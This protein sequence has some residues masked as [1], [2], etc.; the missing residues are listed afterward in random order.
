MALL[1]SNLRVEKPRHREVRSCPQ[2]H[3]TKQQHLVLNLSFLAPELTLNPVLLLPLKW[4]HRDIPLGFQDCWPFKFQIA[5]FL[6]FLLQRK[7]KF[8]EYFKDK[9]QVIGLYSFIHVFVRFSISNQR[10]TMH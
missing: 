3:K 2:D 1:F 9:K 7:I 5:F 4:A 10:M 6:P 8:Q